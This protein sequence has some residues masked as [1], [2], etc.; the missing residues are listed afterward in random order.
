[1]TKVKVHSK[2]LDSTIEVDRIIGH[3]KGHKKGPTL[4]FMGGI[5]GNEPAGVFALKR[6]FERLEAKNV[7]GNIY[8]IAGNL[9]ALKKGERY[10]K[11]DLNRLWTKDLM[12]TLP[13]NGEPAIHYDQ[14]EQMEINKL[15]Q[16]IMQEEE[17]PFY[18]FDMHTTSSETLPF[19]TVNDSLLN[20][21]FTT[22]YPLPI[23][24]GIEEY[25]SGPILSYINELGYVAFGF[26]AGQ[27]DDMASIEN[28]VSFIYL[29]LV[30]CRC[31]QRDDCRYEHHNNILAKTTGDVRHIYEI[32]FR[33]AIKKEEDF[34]MIPGFY[35][36]Q[37]IKRDQHVADSNGKP[38]KAIHDGRI[39]MPLYQSQGE[40]GFFAI[41][42]IWNPFLKISEYIRKYRFDR[43]LAYLPG[44]RWVDEKKSALQ[45]NKRIARFLAK[46]IFHL[47]GYRHYHVDQNHFKM[48]NRE[49]HARYDEYENEPWLNP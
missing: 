31:I 11:E 42:K 13:K 47:F 33:Y 23:I 43:L 9:W 4:V 16:K 38:V 26:E 20:R 2:A 25:L 12:A 6:V 7:S 14:A 36:F 46:D 8:G 34:R 19:L 44:V 37:R 10:H 3:I 48:Y 29:S 24:L 28:C 21:H 5:H 22:Q 15:L 17:G 30:F 27:H 18:F 1:M 35:N 32:Y 39:F 40:D 49:A 41:K 45:V